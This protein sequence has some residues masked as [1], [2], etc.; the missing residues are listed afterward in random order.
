M[1]CN[2]N[3]K[4]FIKAYQYIYYKKRRKENAE[5]L[6]EYERKRKN[7]YR[8]YKRSM[9]GLENISMSIFL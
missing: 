3:D 4:N 8:A 5:E 9:G 2:W 6:R 7:Q 1:E